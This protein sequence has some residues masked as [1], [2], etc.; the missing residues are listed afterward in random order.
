MLD[1]FCLTP[2]R[3]RR[4]THNDCFFVPKRG[5][6]FQVKVYLRFFAVPPPPASIGQVMARRQ[7]RRLGWHC[8]GDGA[9]TPGVRDAH[10]PQLDAH[11]RSDA[12]H[13]GLR[14]EP[15]DDAESPYAVQGLSSTML[16]F[17]GT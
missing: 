5:R 3:M 7:C 17:C 6:D 2:S 11:Q 10:V 16:K 1:E 9:A 14:A 12:H 4:K 13:S 15:E 8:K